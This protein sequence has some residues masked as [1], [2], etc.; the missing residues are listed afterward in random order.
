VGVPVP[1]PADPVPALDP[2]AARVFAVDLTGEPDLAILSAGERARAERLAAEHL[3]R[4]WSRARAALRGVLAAY[5]GADPAVVRIERAPC[6]RCGGPHG[7]PF[8]AA[9]EA[10][11]WLRFNLS[12]SGDL[13]LVA[14][15]HGREVGVDVEEMRPGRPL[16]RI[17]ERG[18]TAAEHAGLR[19][20]PED[21]RDRAFYRLWARKEAYL[22][23]T[24]EGL[25]GWSAPRGELD[26][27]GWDLEDLEV[28]GG[29]A[30]AVAVAPPGYSPGG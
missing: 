1:W 27:E 24:G 5:A 13:A 19:S 11:G 18:F 23:A 21:E 26:R 9:P 16:A 3:T 10:A 29:Y 12:H 17:A 6:V 22:K 14:V 8:L 25:A 15:A 2:G 20:L 28:G 7:K 4:R 30:A